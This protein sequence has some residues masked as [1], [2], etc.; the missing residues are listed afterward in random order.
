MQQQTLPLWMSSGKAA[1]YTEAQAFCVRQ[2]AKRGPKLIRE[3][4]QHLEGMATC[5]DAGEALKVLYL[6]NEL[7]TDLS[8]FNQE[9][10]EFSLAVFESILFPRSI[11]WTA[12]YLKTS[13][14]TTLR[15]L[16]HERGTEP[17]H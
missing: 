2:Y 8:V 1:T 12:N 15:R 5:K 13:F 16:S 7:S 10:N 4:S 11:P 9:W 3:V 14:D 6:L 17:R